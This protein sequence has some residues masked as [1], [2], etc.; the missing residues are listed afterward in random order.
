MTKQQITQTQ[1]QGFRAGRTQAEGLVAPA[2]NPS[3][4]PIQPRNDG[5]S[6][7][8]NTVGHIN[9][10]LLKYMSWQKSIAPYNAKKALADL[11]RTGKATPP[12]NLTDIGYGYQPA[13]DKAQGESIGL[14]LGNSLKEQLPKVLAESKTEDLHMNT[15]ALFNRLK[16]ELI[17]KDASDDFYIGVS[18]YLEKL[19]AE[20]DSMAGQ[21]AKRRHQGTMKG[22]I[23]KQIHTIMANPLLHSEDK[24]QSISNLYKEY[25][26]TMQGVGLNKDDF[27]DLV[28]TDTEA[29]INKALTDDK[30]VNGRTPLEQA[31]EMFRALT[32]PD[33]HGISI[34]DLRDTNGKQSYRQKVYNISATLDTLRKQYNLEA[35]KKKKLKE[36][37]LIDRAYSKLVG[38]DV[39]EDKLI[40][41]KDKLNLLYKQD[42]ISPERY[43]KEAEHLSNNIYT[44]HLRGLKGTN[45]KVVYDPEVANKF[46]IAVNHAKTPSDLKQISE[47]LEKSSVLMSGE[48]FRTLNDKVAKALEELTASNHT[49]VLEGYYRRIDAGDLTVGQDIA[50]D[51]S[52]MHKERQALEER[53]KAVVVDG[54]ILHSNMKQTSTVL[55]A[56]KT[57]EVYKLPHIEL[58]DI[59]RYVKDMAI[60]NLKNYRIAQ[61][62]KVYNVGFREVSNILK[63]LK[64]LGIDNPLMKFDDARKRKA[65]KAAANVYIYAHSMYYSLWNSKDALFLKKYLG[66][67]EFDNTPQGLEQKRQYIMDFLKQYVTDRTQKIL[68]YR[69]ER[70]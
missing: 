5:M 33:K 46:V 32:I 3:F 38:V 24:K 9:Q 49:K 37:T 4:A 60:A 34:M 55:S 50:K 40:A 67:G 14:D 68:E 25:I 2:V 16:G 51:L 63:L 65:A 35:Q 54:D 26:S 69:E 44:M 12:R 22:S 10:A 11:H 18:G 61:S 59:P 58:L 31:E 52:V 20:V 1:S 53:M 70:L 66:R 23:G 56:I 42:L 39:T 41:F 29:S 48:T 45:G 17:P 19:S 64:P 6:D 21:E 43:R 30:I 57:N 62:D 28:L 7:F 13:F 47:Q 36:S 8:A 27:Y 15:R